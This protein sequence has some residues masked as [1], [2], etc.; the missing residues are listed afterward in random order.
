[1]WPSVKHSHGDRLVHCRCL[2]YIYLVKQSLYQKIYVNLLTICLSLHAHSLWWYFWAVEC[3]SWFGKWKKC[4][5]SLGS[6][7][8]LNWKTMQ[9]ASTSSAKCAS[10]KTYLEWW[11]HGSYTQMPLKLQPFTWYCYGS[12][13]NLKTTL[14]FS[15][16]FILRCH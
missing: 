1:M 15:P 13:F 11:W 10:F 4:K 9:W 6:T 3:S 12:N 14:L 16:L 7:Q 8:Q 2:S 5:G